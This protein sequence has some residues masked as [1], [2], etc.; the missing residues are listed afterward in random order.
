MAED[1]QTGANNLGNSTALFKKKNLQIGDRIDLTR[2]TQRLKGGDLKD[3]KSGQILS[4]ENALN[5]GAGSHG[6][7]Y[8]KLKDKFGK[9]IGCISEDGRY[10]RK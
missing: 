8:W 2:F 9:R 4:K 1:G 7:S 5:S 6:G 10:L 3:P